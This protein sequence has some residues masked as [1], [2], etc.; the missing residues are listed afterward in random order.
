MPLSSIVIIVLRLFSL[1]WLLHDVALFA[2]SSLTPLPRDR[3][4]T[5]F[6]GLYGPATLLLVISAGLWIFAP[7][8]ARIVSRGADTTVG[9]GSLS[10][11]DLYSFGFVFLGLYFILS[12][13]AETIN[14]IHYFAAVSAKGGLPI[15]NFYQLTKP[16]LTLAAGFTSLLGAP[17]WAKKIITYEQRHHEV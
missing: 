2:S 8:I 9:I 4:F 17:R 11:Y 16:I 15:Q 5:L 1:N 6:L 3:S 14:W 10:R 7:S 12:S 13:I